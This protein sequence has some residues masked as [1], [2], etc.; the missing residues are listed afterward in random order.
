MCGQRE[1]ERISISS[2]LRTVCTP[3]G[4]GTH[5]PRDHDRS[6]NQESE[7]SPAEPPRLRLPTGKFCL[8]V[9]DLWATGI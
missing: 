3:L 5:E 9:D 1:R 6:Q 2:R 4:A 8:G 7:A